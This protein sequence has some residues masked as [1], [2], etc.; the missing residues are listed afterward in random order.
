MDRFLNR[1]EGSGDAIL[2]FG[3]YS[4]VGIAAVAAAVLIWYAYRRGRAD[5]ACWAALGLAL[6]GPLTASV[7]TVESFQPQDKTVIIAAGVVGALLGAVLARS[8]PAGFP[9]EVVGAAIAVAGLAVRPPLSNLAEVGQAWVYPTIAVLLVGAPAFAIA[10]GLTRMRLVHDAASLTLGLAV[11]VLAGFAMRPTV[12]RALHPSQT[13]LSIAVVSV[14]AAA[15]VLIVVLHRVSR[16]EQQSH[17]EIREQ[18]ETQ[19]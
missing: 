2:E 19:P 4:S 9:W 11:A 15:I 16:G 13:K 5:M 17:G 6:A 10:S 3:Y 1:P 18:A 14:S 8:G 12:L 7:L